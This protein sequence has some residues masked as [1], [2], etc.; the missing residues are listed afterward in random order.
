MG[1]QAI[2]QA[3]CGWRC[4]GGGVR[5]NFQEEFA[6]LSQLFVDGLLNLGDGIGQLP[7]PAGMKIGGLV[8]MVGRTNALEDEDDDE[9]ENDSCRNS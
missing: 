2:D 4:A 5:L 1:R 9:Y 6:F 3:D 8:V 7:S